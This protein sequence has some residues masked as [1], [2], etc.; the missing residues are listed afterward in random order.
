[1]R[2]AAVNIATAKQAHK[3]HVDGVLSPIPQMR[4]L[5]LH[6]MLI[7]KERE[8]RPTCGK[9]GKDQTFFFTYF[10]LNPS[11]ITFARF[12][13]ILFESCTKF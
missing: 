4:A 9:N 8:K 1:M 12:E 3:E 13:L 10:V 11:Q 7:K 2:G 6:P 5:I